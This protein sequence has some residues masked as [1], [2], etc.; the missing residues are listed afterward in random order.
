MVPKLPSWSHV[1]KPVLPK[2]WAL[3]FAHTTDS[4]FR[5]IKKPELHGDFLNTNIC[6]YCCFH[7]RFM[8]TSLIQEKC[9][10]WIRKLGQILQITC[11]T[12]LSLPS[13]NK[14]AVV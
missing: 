8:Q 10:V 11:Y 7:F 3:Q 2:T 13:P 14:Q 1:M 12:S 6:Y 9:E 5:V 4:N